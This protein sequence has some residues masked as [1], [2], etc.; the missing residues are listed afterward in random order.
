MQDTAI[1]HEIKRPVDIQRSQLVALG[2]RILFPIRSPREFIKPLLFITQPY[3]QVLRK[4]FFSQLFKHFHLLISFH[5]PL[6]AAL[7]LG[8]NLHG[9]AL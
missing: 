3:A 1:T 9:A 4:L 5:Q 2:R 8:L 6:A 7:D